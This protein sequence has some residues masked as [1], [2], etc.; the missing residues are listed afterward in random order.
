[1]HARFDDFLA[2][3]TNGPAALHMEP[4][5][6]STLDGNTVYNNQLSGNM[7]PQAPNVTLALGYEHTWKLTGDNGFNFRAEAKYQSKQ[8]FD[9]FNY[10]DSQQE[11]Y[12]TINAYIGYSTEKWR[13]NLFGRNLADKV[14]LVD[15]AE[16]TTG[17]AHTYRYGFGALRTFGIHF[18]GN[19]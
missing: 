6:A 10:N 13:V 2:S 17:G 18:E 1:L 8:Y 12:T 4:V 7:L 16:I 3:P 15:A 11:G 19:L 5:V 14:Y 9:S